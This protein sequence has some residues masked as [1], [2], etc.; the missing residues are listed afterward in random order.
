MSVPC[1]G[2]V[3]LCGADTMV[4]GAVSGYLCDLDSVSRDDLVGR[5][6]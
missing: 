6:D 4:P 1:A 3:E 5:L 2:D